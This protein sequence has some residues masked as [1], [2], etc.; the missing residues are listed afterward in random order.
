MLI[1]EHALD[2]VSAYA[3]Y[4]DYEDSMHRRGQEEDINHLNRN[5]GGVLHGDDAL[6]SPVST[7]VP[8][9]SKNTSGQGNE[10]TEPYED[11]AKRLSSND[12]TV[13]MKEPLFTNF[14]HVFSGC[15]DYLFYS[16][17]AL[18][19]DR[20]RRW[21]LRSEYEASSSNGLPCADF[22]SDHIPL[23]TVFRMKG[24]L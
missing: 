18:K 13:G 15:L 11:I 23:A 20:S 24:S 8:P 16:R 21:P 7:S 14:T 12:D 10:K 2:L 17:G 19:M 3:D 1:L 6:T 5:L 4:A 9:S 22:P